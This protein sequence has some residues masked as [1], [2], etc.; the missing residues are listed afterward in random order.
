MY[1]NGTGPIPTYH[2]PGPVATLSLVP[3]FAPHATA[4]PAPI[5]ANSGNKIFALSGASL[6]G[7]VAVA[8]FVL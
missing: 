7:L 6:A 1:T 4:S 5:E 8:A 3:T 2:A